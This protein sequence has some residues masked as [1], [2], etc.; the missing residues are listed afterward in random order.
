MYELFLKAIQQHHLPSRVRVDQ[1]GENVMVATHMLEKRGSDR[2]SVIVGSS[3]HNQRIERLWR[4]MHRCVTILFYKLF[5]FMEQTD[6]LD[7]LNEKHLFALQFVYIPRINHALSEFKNGW[8][9]HSIRTAHHKSPHQL[10]TAGALLL[11]HSG[12]AGLDFFEDVD[13][14]YGVDVDAPPASEESQVVVPPLSVRI[15]SQQLVDLKHRINPLESSDEFGIDL[16]EQTLHY[17]LNI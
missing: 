6:I 7:P 5:Y 10:F 3:V 13:D 15:T 1:G 12:L 14:E 2:R 4:D 16:Y 11:Q 17:L 9:H 8:N